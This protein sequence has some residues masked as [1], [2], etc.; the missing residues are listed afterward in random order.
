MQVASCDGSSLQRLVS[1]LYFRWRVCMRDTDASRSLFYPDRVSAAASLVNAVALSDECVRLV[2]EAG[3]GTAGVL[4]QAA[5]ELSSRGLRC[6]L[7]DGSAS[8]GLALRALITQIIGR[9]DPATLSD[10]DLEAGFVAL[11]E[12]GDGCRRVILLVAEAHD[13]QPSAMQYIQFACQSGA[14]LRVVLAGR[15]SLDATLASDKL[16]YLRQRLTRTIQVA[17]SASAQRTLSKLFSEGV[18]ASPAPAMVRRTRFWPWATLGAATSVVLLLALS[19]ATTGRLHS[20]PRSTAATHADLSSPSVHA[21]VISA[22][23]SQAALSDADRK[24]PTTGLPVAQ[25]QAAAPA[26]MQP[27]QPPAAPAPLKLAAMPSPAE[28]VSPP[29]GQPKPVSKPA[30]KAMPPVPAVA[31]RDGIDLVVRQAPGAFDALDALP[32]E[33]PPASVEPASSHAVLQSEPS[34][35]GQAVQ[36]TQGGEPGLSNAPAIET[37]K[38]LPVSATAADPPASPP[39]PQPRTP[40]GLP[41]DA[42][43]T[44]HPRP[45]AERAAAPVSALAS[46]SADGR[47]C[48]DIVLYVQLGKSLSDA[49]KKFLRDDCRAQSTGR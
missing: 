37:P 34:G 11:T 9:A 1:A 10:S 47:H 31:I 2:S 26:L 32:P 27:S 35:A 36:P 19:M 23:A 5:T 14:K 12:P 6:I 3:A 8:G 20:P 4:D 30:E 49:D 43:P 39:K 15:R 7:V 22:P 40:A 48:R 18:L 16:S 29:S 25:S 24:Q 42:V 28:P 46:R 38:P 41:A 45:G 17:T 13:L 33:P 44:R 21:P